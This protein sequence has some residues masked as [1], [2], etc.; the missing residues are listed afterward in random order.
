MCRRGDLNLLE[1]AVTVANGQLHRKPIVR[2]L[3]ELSKLRSLG[4]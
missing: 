4:V 1:S 2:R 3:E